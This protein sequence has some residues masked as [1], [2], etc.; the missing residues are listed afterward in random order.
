[1]AITHI[2]LDNFRSYTNRGFSLDPGVTLIIGP[3]GSGKTNILEALYVLATT[4]SF[5]AR[6][7]ALIR[8]GSDVLRVVATSSESEYGFAY[9]S[10]PTIT[11]KVTHDGV[12][13]TL[14]GHIGSVPV[15][16]FEPGDLQLLAGPPSARRGYIDT[17]LCQTDPD[18][19]QALN[20][21]KRALRQ[22]NAL[23]RDHSFVPADVLFA[24]N[25]QLTG[26][27]I[28]LRAKR[29][30]FIAYLQHRLPSL[31]ASIAGKT[32]ELDIQYQPNPDMSIVDE[33]GLLET[34]ESVLQRDTAAGFTT[35]GPHRD[36]FAV[37]FDGH[38]IDARASR[39]E[40]RS[41]VLSLK[42]AEL[43]YQNEFARARPLFMLDD[44]F[45]ELDSYRRAFLLKTIGDYQTIVTTTEAD[46]LKDSGYYTIDLGVKYE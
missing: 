20:E 43:E 37:M 44:V 9:Q 33:A 16:L 40:H 23:L 10:K 6:D 30:E 46:S 1:M 11:K 27:A 26:P 5:R 8:Q 24:W 35:V 45:S 21:Y 15:V 41:V 22:R 29:Q 12:K 34:F 3:N 4:R 19:L 2:A 28:L 18:Y 32:H 31:Y 17:I 14:R 39:G 25:V 42:L 7:E 36:D 13:K 38:S